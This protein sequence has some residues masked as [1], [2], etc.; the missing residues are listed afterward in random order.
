[1]KIH[2]LFY[3]CVIFFLSTANSFALGQAA[4]MGNLQTVLPSG[5][6]DTA[7]NPALLTAQTQTNSTGVFFDYV[8]H[9]TKENSARAGSHQEWYSDPGNAL[10]TTNNTSNELRIEDPEIKAYNINIANST[11]FRS[12]AIGFAFVNN[13]NDQYSVEDSKISSIISG[14]I[15][16]PSVNFYKES[17]EKSEKTELNPAF[18]TSIG[19]NISNTSSAGFQLLAKY[20][21]STEKKEYYEHM[22]LP[23]TYEKKE[24]ITKEINALSG[25]IGFGYFFRADNSEIGL[26]IRSGEFSWIKKSLSADTNR[27]STV[28]N[29]RADKSITLNGKYTSGPS[30]AVG[31]YKRF[32][33]FF[34]LGLESKFTVQNSFTNKE[35]E[36]NDKQ[37]GPTSVKIKK[38]TNTTKNS[39]L[40]NGGIQFNLSESLSFNTGIGYLKVAVENSGGDDNGSHREENN[41][42]YSLLTVGFDY[43]LSKNVEITLI[44]T[45]IH[46]SVDGSRHGY[47]ESK[48]AGFI[49][50]EDN[51]IE[52]KSRGYYVHTGLGVSLSF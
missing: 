48:Q 40:F 24:K 45:G 38:G 8:S 20:S 19:F 13:G 26:L 4:S 33:S 51:Y 18:I 11:K 37:S 47:S 41:I 49:I 30:I 43:V 5:P 17:N 12:S 44:A 15:N 34:A 31:S 35:L 32:N 50:E 36:L 10:L 39:V 2:S 42:E 46:Y 52:T 1:M 21:D 16:Y 22:T 9:T 3:F 23:S 25:E 28:E 29:L 7:R 27:I 6:F 14:T